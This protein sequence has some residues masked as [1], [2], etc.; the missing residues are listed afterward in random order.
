MSD[1]TKVF[2][3]Q[4]E[5]LAYTITVYEDGGAF[6][7]DIAVSEGAMDVNAIYFGDDEFT[8][9]S[10]SLS[11]PLNM[12]G[13]RLDGER[14]QWDEAEK[15]SDPGLGPEG[16]DKETYVAAGDTL[17]VELDISSLDEVDV[18][19]I[20]AT[21]TT[22]E[23]GSIKAVS[24][25]PEEEEPEEELTFQKVFFGEEFT[26]EGHPFG[27]A[28][29]SAEE[30]APND[31]NVP[32]LP[33]GTE[34]TFDNYVSY[35]ESIGGDVTGLEGVVFY[36]NDEEGTL[37]EVYRLDPPE[38]GFESAD[39]LLSLYAQAVEDGAFD[40]AVGEDGSLELMAA[41]SLGEDSGYDVP[42]EEDVVE[43]DMEMV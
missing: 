17:T 2:T 9:S 42:E 12:N 16:E 21:S 33:E 25:E 31:F 15:L 13:V 24:D 26:E 4:V 41:L 7:A 36:N 27:G 38:G 14:V 3:Y 20:R 39:Q 22:T 34:P 37:Q 8:G 30:P 35:Y 23:E 32:F 29:V 10:E 43:D 19:G 5:G 18:F 6:Y 28:F 40:S 1:H 11:G